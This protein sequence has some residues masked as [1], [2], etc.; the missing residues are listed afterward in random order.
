MK[1][2]NY[3]KLSSIYYL[4]ASLVCVFFILGFTGVLKNDII[5]SLLIQIVAMLIVPFC[6]YTLFVS[7]NPKQ[8][9]KDTGIKK[10]SLKSVVLCFLLGI[11]LYFLNS[12]IANFFSTSLSL[13]GWENLYAKFSSATVKFSYGLLIKEFIL[14]AILPAI[15][16]EFLH[17]GM[18]L[19]AGKKY[20]N[21]KFCLIISSIL[22][23]LMHLN[24]QQFF[25]ASILG[26][27]MG[28][29]TLV[30]DSIIPSIILHFMN[31]ALSTYFYYGSVLGWKIPTTYS[32]VKI[33]LSANKLLNIIISCICLFSIIYLII[34]LIK[35]LK[36][37][38]ANNRIK[39]FV[40]KLNFTNLPISEMQA[41]IDE[42]NKIIK[43]NKLYTFKTVKK[44]GLK[45]NV[46]IISSFVLTGLITL[47][48]LIWGLI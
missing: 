17:R 37:E 24:V 10:I 47:S 1:N 34:Y 16:E 18:L 42:I 46:F 9:L 21:T 41:K 36:E 44:L 13:L 35:K 39:E 11:L 22:F 31:N 2:K 38:Q 19:H 32:N 7:K 4:A 45:N 6:L 23:G 15:C 8:T 30:A 20:G 29:I 25:Y 3:L 5:S 33:I 27:I 28:Y 43:D 26:F 48:S 12:F 40:K 14:S